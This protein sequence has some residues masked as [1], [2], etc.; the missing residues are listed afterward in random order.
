M[1]AMPQAP[2][3]FR[4]GAFA[5]VL[6]KLTACEWYTPEPGEGPAWKRIFKEMLDMRN[7]PP[8][9]CTAFISH[10]GLYTWDCFIEGPT[11][12]PYEHGVFHLAV[13]FPKGY[14]SIPPKVRFVTKVYHPKIK[15]NGFVYLHILHDNWSPALTVAK[16][17]ASLRSLLSDPESHV[18]RGESDTP[19]LIPDIALLGRHNRAEYDRQAYLVTNMYACPEYLRAGDQEKVVQITDL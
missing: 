11:D 17:L 4:A 6:R 5:A 19:V 14:P 12:T 2:D 13:E 15:E 16:V 7:A 1:P 10:K 9:G 18:E 8:L 3:E